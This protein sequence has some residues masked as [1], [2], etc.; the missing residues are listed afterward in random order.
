MNIEL[1]EKL[2]CL[3]DVRLH[4]IAICNINRGGRLRLPRMD[5]L[6]VHYVLQGS[7]VLAN[8]DSEPLE[9]APGAVIF[10]RAANLLRATSLPI[11]VIGVSVGYARRSY[12]SRAFRAAYGKDPRSF[13][14]AARDAPERSLSVPSKVVV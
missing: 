12:F 2:L 7:G 3:L 9:F 11:Q 14:Q 10:N 6:L 5:R 13:R 1:I 8:P 4:A